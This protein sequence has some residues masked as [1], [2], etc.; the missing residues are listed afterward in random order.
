[1]SQSTKVLPPHGI[2][3]V[4]AQY[5]SSCPSWTRTGS[6]FTVKSAW[7][8]HT[9]HTSRGLQLPIH[10]SKA[11]HKM[12]IQ[13]IGESSSCRISGVTKHPTN[14]STYYRVDN[15]NHTTPC[16]VRREAPMSFSNISS[17]FLTQ[18]V[19]LVFEQRGGPCRG[20][21]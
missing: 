10:I 19:R 5:S 8:V 2:K 12:R 15:G 1:M 18:F 17:M 16:M 13:Q 4:R 3:A 9:M 6:R 20:V 14:H 7:F 11:K 21:R